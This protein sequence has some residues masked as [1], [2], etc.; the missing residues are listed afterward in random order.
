M[1]FA[2][3]SAHRPFAIA[4]LDFSV[5]AGECVAIVGPSGAKSTIFHLLLRFYDPPAG[6][7]RVAG[8]NLCDLSL[9]G[10]ARTHRASAAGINLL[11]STLRRQYHLANRMLTRR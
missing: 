11:L 5:A 4:D 8:S 6:R 2:Y 7:V 3:P 1:N 10:V 9:T